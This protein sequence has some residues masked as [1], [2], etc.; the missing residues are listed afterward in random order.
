MT[1][2]SK[3]SLP[4]EALARISRLELQARTIVEGFLSGLHRSPYFG[5]SVEF[6]QHREYVPGDDFRRI[7]WKVLSKTDKVYIKLFEEETNLRSTILVDV[8]ES[9]QFGSRGVTKYDYA[10]VLAGCLAYLLLRQ[11]DSVGLIAFDNDVRD[12][13]PPR[14]KRNHLQA[15]LAALQTEEPQAKTDIEQILRKVA[16]EQSKKGMI[17]LISDLLVER[18]GL[19]RGL[20]LLRHRGHDVMLFH[21]LDDAE[22][23]FEYSGTTKFEG[24]EELPDLICDPR[25]LRDGYLAALHEY[26]DEIRRH[27]A[28]H[29][30]DYQTVRTSAKVDA[31]LAHYL[32]HRLG[33]HPS[34]RG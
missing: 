27:C 29:T 28:G 12:V 34:V 4:P 3:R 25:S 16:D 6:V 22:L 20:K 7:D 19:F 8:S 26:L 11:Q 14:S 31:V 24:L 30:V 21:V 18:P 32:H 10:S 23:D 9:M 5:Q 33:L 13:I 2:D 17:I 1:H 15:L